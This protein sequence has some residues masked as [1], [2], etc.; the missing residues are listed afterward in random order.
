MRLCYKIEHVNDNSAHYEDFQLGG[1]WENPL[2]SESESHL[3]DFL[4][5]AEGINSEEALRGAIQDCKN[6]LAKHNLG[7]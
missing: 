2:L 5:L 1:C 3:C 4:Y 7:L 6:F